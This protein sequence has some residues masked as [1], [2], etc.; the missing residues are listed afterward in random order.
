MEKSNERLGAF[1]R[2]GPRTTLTRC[3]Q[4]WNIGYPPSVLSALHDDR[5]AVLHVSD[6]AGHPGEKQFGTE[7][8][9]LGVRALRYSHEGV[10]GR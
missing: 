4:K 7:R 5:V 8:G 2:N 9:R 6:Y 10:G 1:Q 3:M